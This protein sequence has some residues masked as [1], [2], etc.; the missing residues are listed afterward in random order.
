MVV[1][2]CNTSSTS[3]AGAGELKVEALVPGLHS[4][5]CL[6]ATTTIKKKKTLKQNHSVVIFVALS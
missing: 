6:K 2:T 5:T 3:E 1:H 4:K